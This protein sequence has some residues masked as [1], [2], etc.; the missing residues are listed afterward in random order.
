MKKSVCLSQDSNL[1]SQIYL[2]GLIQPIQGRNRVKLQREEKP[3]L[4]E[5]RSRIEKS[6]H[7][8]EATMTLFGYICQESVKTNI[9][10]HFST[11]HAVTFEGKYLKY[12]GISQEESVFYQ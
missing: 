4:P 7:S 11:G 10:L 8:R 1:G 6:G 12:I 5:G 3:S 9:L 2:Y